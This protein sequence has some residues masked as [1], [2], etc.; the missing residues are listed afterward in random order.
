MA[1]EVRVEPTADEE[2]GPGAE[3]GSSRNSVL[4][5]TDSYEEIEEYLDDTTESTGHKRLLSGTIHEIQCENDSPTSQP[6]LNHTEDRD[7]P[8]VSQVRKFRYLTFVA[9]HVF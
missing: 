6:V 8:S 5:S 1:E 9:L 3:P 7:S 2:I 4:V